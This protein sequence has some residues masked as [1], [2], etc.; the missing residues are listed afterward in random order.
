MK[1]YV[2]HL[3]KPMKTLTLHCVRV[4]QIHAGRES[5]KGDDP[6]TDHWHPKETASQ[7][8]SRADCFI[9]ATPSRRPDAVGWA[10]LVGRAR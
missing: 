5:Q 9:N 10:P 6:R 2:H 3:P 7:L 8:P 1:W 4:K